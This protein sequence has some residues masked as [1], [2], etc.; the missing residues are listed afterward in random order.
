MNPAAF[1]ARIPSSVRGS[2]SDTTLAMWCAIHAYVAE[3]G[4]TDRFDTTLRKQLRATR[5]KWIAESTMQRHLKRLTDAGLLQAHPLL[6][7]PNVFGKLLGGFSLL[8]SS[9]PP[10]GMFIRYT[11][12]GMEPTL[13]SDGPKIGTSQVVTEVTHEN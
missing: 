6:V 10:P 5:G 3:H 2:L 12:P 11:L 4:Q 8:A 1:A 13:E 7:K 9:G